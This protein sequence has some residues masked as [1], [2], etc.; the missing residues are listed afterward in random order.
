MIYGFIF[1]CLVTLFS[2]TVSKNVY[3]AANSII[4]FFF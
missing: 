4:S 1:L 3:D 2:M